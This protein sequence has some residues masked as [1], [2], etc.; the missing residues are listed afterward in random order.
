MD[1]SAIVTGGAGGIGLAV[2]R[3]L[4]LAGADI[5]LVDRSAP[6]TSA[7][8]PIESAGRRVRFVEADVRSFDD[9][10][11]AVREVES[12]LG[13]C[14]VLVACAGISRDGASWRMSEK[15]WRDVIDVNL[16]GAFTFVRAVTPGM[17]ARGRGRIVL[18]SSINGLRGKFGLANYAASKA[19]LIGLT[20]TLARELG[21]KG[22]TV[23]A[24]APGFIRTPMTAALPAE[25][26]ETA[27]RESALGRLG[28]PADVAS[29][30]S[31]LC[32]EGAAYVTGEVIKVDGGQY[33]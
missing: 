16:T 4:A 9:A 19:A 15:D 21:P 22:I 33:I 29:V 18:V 10:D 17:R 25:V 5:G 24:V 14:D 26:V 32:S 27:R 2:A 31:F 23:N 11:R 12:S 3:E 20:K 30:I 6:P 8:A 13:P 7:V 28:D 1:G